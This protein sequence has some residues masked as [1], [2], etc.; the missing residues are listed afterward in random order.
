[1]KHVAP[2]KFFRVPP[3][4][5]YKTKKCFS[6]II[7]AGEG[8]TGSVL[9]S[10]CVEDVS[11]P[12]T[13]LSSTNIATIRFRTDGSVT[14]FGFLAAVKVGESVKLPVKPIDTSCTSLLHCW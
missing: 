14:N 12:A 4:Y 3:K 9:A 2:A 8:I 5:I 10:L 7:L 6:P 11:G 13:Y 1:M